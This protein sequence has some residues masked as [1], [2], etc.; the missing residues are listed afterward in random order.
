MRRNRQ[1]ACVY[2]SLTSPESVILNEKSPSFDLA[3]CT[4]LCTRPPTKEDDEIRRADLAKL[5]AEER[6]NKE[7]AAKETEELRARGVLPSKEEKEVGG[8]GHK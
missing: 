8:P 4:N 1:K 6:F 2:G 7:R 5:K 3:E